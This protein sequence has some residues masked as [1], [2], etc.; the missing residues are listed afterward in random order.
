M[1]TFEGIIKGDRIEL[2]RSVKIPWDVPTPAQPA[3]NAPAIGPAPDG[4]DPSIDPSWSI[5]R[6]IPVVLRRVQG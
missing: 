5:P 4:S 2:Q 6:S 1:N 3:P